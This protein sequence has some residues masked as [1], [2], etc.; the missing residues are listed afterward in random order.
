MTQPQS[1]LL[2]DRVSGGGIRVSSGLKK[3]PPF[4]NGRADTLNDRADAIRP[5][6]PKSAPNCAK[7]KL[8]PYDEAYF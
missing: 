4:V 3:E 2:I 7:I 1:L 8:F 5:N 6:S